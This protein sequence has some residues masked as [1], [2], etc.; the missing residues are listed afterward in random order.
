MA[1]HTLLGRED[2]ASSVAEETSTRQA[3]LTKGAGTPTFRGRRR[4]IC[5]CHGLGGQIAYEFDTRSEVLA[6]LL[7]T[8][9]DAFQYSVVVQLGEEAIWIPETLVH[10]LED[11]QEGLAVLELASK[12]AVLVE[13]VDQA[14]AIA[15][16]CRHADYGGGEGDFGFEAIQTV[17]SRSAPE[18]GVDVLR[19]VHG[20]QIE[21]GF[22]RVLTRKTYRQVPVIT[23]QEGDGEV[24]V[25]LG[26][27]AG[28]EV[29]A[30]E[31]LCGLAGGERVVEPALSDGHGA[32]DGGGT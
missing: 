20:V 15:R 28:L 31:L 3:H 2:D 18:D 11:E 29:R 4:A 27:E 8:F 22:C 17:A 12:V 1:S 24:E 21:C 32:G 25:V 9:H 5:H 30:E 26:E 16:H 10:V 7:F 14:E 23:G 6:A 13:V 19:A